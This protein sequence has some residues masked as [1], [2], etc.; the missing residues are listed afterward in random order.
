VGLILASDYFGM[1]IA[2]AVFPL[3]LL[4]ELGLFRTLFLVASLNA[5]AA[6]LLKPERWPHLSPTLGML[7]AGFL[8]EPLIRQ[9][10][11][12]AWLGG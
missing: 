5:F 8:Y 2:C 12:H 10:L 9:W 3:F 7:A 1:L 6:L 11:G 4:P